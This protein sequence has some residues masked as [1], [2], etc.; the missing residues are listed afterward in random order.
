[1]SRRLSPSLQASSRQTP[2][3]AAPSRKLYAPLVW[4]AANPAHHYLLTLD[5][6]ESRHTMMRVLHR[7]AQLM[8]K[9]SLDAIPWTEL[10]A[11]HV[12]HVINTLIEK[13]QSP[14]YAALVLAAIKGVCRQAFLHEQMPVQRYT[15]IKE[16]RRR[17][18]SRTRGAGQPLPHAI[19]HAVIAACQADTTLAGKRDLVV[20][21]AVYALG[22][23]RNEVATLNFPGNFD[24]DTGKVTVIGK[25]NKERHIP[26]P[27]IF[28]EWLLDYLEGRGKSPGPLLQQLKRTA[29]GLKFL[30]KRLSSQSVY[31]I[32]VRRARGHSDVH[33]TPHDFRRTF[34]TELNESNVDLTTV[35]EL[36]GHSSVSTTH[37][38]IRQRDDKK[39]KA[40]INQLSFGKK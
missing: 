11:Q 38:Y 8:G 17:K 13:G 36:L 35:A 28:E 22:L 21:G 32:C 25:G 23:R 16:I 29:Q 15:R 19:L 14:N 20:L 30:N 27:D 18:G 7:V 4:D 33:F 2:L 12:Q 31:N 3:R 24:F 37:K 9:A 5:D 39:Q 10:D 26:M 40:E 1:M 34:G 6:G